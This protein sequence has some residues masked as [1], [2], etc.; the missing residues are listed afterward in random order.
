MLSFEMGVFVHS[1]LS[2]LTCKLKKANQF[3][4][5]ILIYDSFLFEFTPTK[6]NKNELN[7]VLNS[8]GM[9][10]RFI[11]FHKVRWIMH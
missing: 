6:F 3:T 2:F 10:H 8:V 4:H 11:I 1:W 9:Q 5:M 7:K